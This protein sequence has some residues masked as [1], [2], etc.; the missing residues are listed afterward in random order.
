VGIQIRG[1]ERRSGATFL[2]ASFRPSR[3]IAALRAYMRIRD[4]HL[5]YA[6]AHMGKPPVAVIY[7]ASALLT[8]TAGPLTVSTV[9]TARLHRAAAWRSMPPIYR[10]LSQ[11]DGC[12]LR[13]ALPASAG[14]PA[15]LGDVL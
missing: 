7:L 6:G 5:E 10:W 11:P 2:L 9:T 15:G 13:I 3:D 4:R 1:Q 12:A 8:T 14:A